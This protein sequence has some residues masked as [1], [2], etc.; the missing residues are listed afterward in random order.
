MLENSPSNMPS[1]L[2]I[3][4]TASYCVPTV[5]TDLDI[6][7]GAETNHPSDSVAN[8]GRWRR[9]KKELYLH[10]AE[11]TAWLYV[12]EAKVNELTAD[13]QVVMD[14]KVGGQCPGNSSETSWERRLGTIWLLR[15]NHNGENHRAVTSVDVLFGE[16]AVDLRPQWTLSQTP[17]QLGAMNEIPVARLSV[18][19]G[20]ET[21]GTQPKLKAGRKGIFKIVQIS[22]TH[23]VTGPGVC[24]DAIDANGQPLPP[25]QADPLTVNFLGRVLDA[26]RPDLVVLTGDQ[27][28][29][30]IP[31]SQSALFKVVAPVIERSIPYAAVFGNHDDEGAYALSRK[32]IARYPN[33]QAVSRCLIYFGPLKGFPV[34]KISTGSDCSAFR[35]GT[36][37]Y[38]SQSAIQPLPA[39]PKR[40]GRH[41]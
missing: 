7:F 19:H 36:D 41:R 30:D 2:D 3:F 31:D 21:V 14:V 25:S 10:M 9:I 4:P 39:R 11:K 28:H 8:S 6:N 17:F 13:D 27:I 18:R 1:P 38:T 5:V 26:E 34:W 16:D 40:S 15:S 22:D 20:S 24:K 29:H 35:F 32:Q 33:Q 37:G 12:A 23:M